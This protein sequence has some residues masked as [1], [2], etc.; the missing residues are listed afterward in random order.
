MNKQ[1]LTGDL[2]LCIKQGFWCDD[3][4]GE[5]VTIGPKAGQVLT[6]ARVSR[7]WHPQRRGDLLLGFA[8]HGRD[9]FAASRFVKIEPD[10]TDEIDKQCQIDLDLRLPAELVEARV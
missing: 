9:Y 8:E 5:Y 7:N 1:W 2:A 4:T 6:V 3:A 10:E